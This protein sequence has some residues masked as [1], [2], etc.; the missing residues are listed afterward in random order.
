[1]TPRRDADNPVVELFAAPL[2]V[3]LDVT[4]VVRRLAHRERVT[5]WAGSWSR[6]ALVTCD[7][8]REMPAGAD[9]FDV[10][11]SVPELGPD[12][13]FPDAVGGGWF[14]Y[15]GFA[16]TGHR[17]RA[18]LAWYRDVLRHDG[19]RW[20]YEALLGPGGDPGS[21]RTGEATARARCAELCADLARPAP[22]V[23]AARIAVER[24]PDRD[25]HLAAVEACIGEIRRGEIYQAN[26]ACEIEL[27]LRGGVHEAWARI[28]EARSGGGAPARA[29][30]VADR[31]EPAGQNFVRG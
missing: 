24:W 9:P 5:A 17:P 10:L 20:W 16:D 28:V 29:A 21:C 22:A 14:G 12:P 26:I 27:S 11:G 25:A 18:S 8:V 15:L 19:E 13:R 31:D 7:P 23:E 1:M 6:G 2:T 30:L 4:G 3:E